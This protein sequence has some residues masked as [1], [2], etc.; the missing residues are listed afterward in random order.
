MSPAR[1]PAPSQHMLLWLPED[2]NGGAEERKARGEEERT[3][4]NATTLDM[5][6]TKTACDRDTDEGLFSCEKVHCDEML[7][8]N[9]IKIT[10]A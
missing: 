5:I 7:W 4:E 1:G 6:Q 10:H 3:R 2:K 9:D 8:I